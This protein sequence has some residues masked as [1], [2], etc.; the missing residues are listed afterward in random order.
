V[1]GTSSVPDSSGKGETRI[2]VPKSVL[3]SW[4]DSIKASTTRIETLETSVTLQKTKIASL[5][6]IVLKQGES[7]R[8]SEQRIPSLQSIIDDSLLRLE[9]QGIS[10]ENMK[11]SLDDSEAISAAL[12]KTLIGLSGD[13]E[14]MR[15]SRV[16]DIIISALAGLVTGGGGVAIILLS[17]R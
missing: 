17:S 9:R 15:S 4:S 12:Q 13:L 3:K 5:R 11:K 6:Q 8:T 16:R 1:L 2:E 14:A 10:L 7:L